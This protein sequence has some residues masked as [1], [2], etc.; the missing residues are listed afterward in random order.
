MR[1]RKRTASRGKRPSSP[2]GL[3]PGLRMKGGVLYD[4]QEGGFVVI[5]HTWDN[6]AGRG[7]PEEWRGPDVFP[8]EEAAMRYYKAHLRPA[9][10][11]MMADTAGR[12]PGLSFRHRELEE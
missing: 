8:T 10:K 9:L 2:K 6:I 11:Q 7:M 1:R 4:P 3:K 12:D 5:V